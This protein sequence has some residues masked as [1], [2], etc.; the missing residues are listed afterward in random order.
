[1]VRAFATA[2]VAAVEGCVF[3]ATPPFIATVAAVGDCKNLVAVAGASTTAIEAAVEVCMMRLDAVEGCAEVGTS[4]TA[5]VVAVEDCKNLR[6]V[7]GASG[8]ASNV[9]TEACEARLETRLQTRLNKRLDLLSRQ[10]LVTANEARPERFKTRLNTRLNTRLVLAG[11]RRNVDVYG[12]IVPCACAFHRVAAVPVVCHVCLLCRGV[13]CVCTRRCG[14]AVLAPG[15]AGKR[16]TRVNSTV[17]PRL[18]M[19]GAVRRPQPGRHHHSPARANM[20]VNGQ[21]VRTL[22]P[23]RGAPRLAPL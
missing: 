18:A 5:T 20:G 12:D 6:V 16:E 1:M 15:A 21:V 9:S 19:P 14:V 22:Q 4:S 8:T 7:V 3:V 17:L 2:T 23:Q 11:Q 10:D 13:L